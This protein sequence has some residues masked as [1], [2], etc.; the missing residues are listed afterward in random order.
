M[1]ESDYLEL[2]GYVTYSIPFFTIARLSWFLVF[3]LRGLTN[4]EGTLEVTLSLNGSHL[5]TT[6]SLYILAL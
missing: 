2:F 6:C 3:E 4:S 5:E 1:P